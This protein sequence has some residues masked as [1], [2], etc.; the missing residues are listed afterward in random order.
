MEVYIKHLFYWIS[1]YKSC[2]QGGDLNKKQ[3]NRKIMLKEPASGNKNQL[4]ITSK[5]AET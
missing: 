2:N 1:G 3:G 5:N 4:Y